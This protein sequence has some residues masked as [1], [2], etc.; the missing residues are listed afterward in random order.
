[1]AI[2]TRRRDRA[3]RLRRVGNHGMDRHRT[4]R[5]G[6]PYRHWD[7]VELGYKAN[8]TDLEAALLRPQL[9]WI[10]SRRARR[11]ALA[12]RYEAHLREAVPALRGPAPSERGIPWLV[13]PRGTS[14]RNLFTLH[15]PALRRDAILASLGAQGIGTAVNFRAIHRLAY[16]VARHRVTCGAPPVPEQISDR[17]CSLR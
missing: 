8:L 4:N 15:A 5:D 1:G 17:T 13:E 11:E 10:E 2:A 12:R 7:I 6:K 3:E 9:A 16:F 14:S